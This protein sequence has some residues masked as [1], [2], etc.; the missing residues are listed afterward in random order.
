MNI[1]ELKSKVE[2]LKLPASIAYATRFELIKSIV[3]N[4]VQLAKID[5][6]ICIDIQDNITNNYGSFDINNYI[7]DYD[8][9]TLCMS[10]QVSN[11]QK[12]VELDFNI[13]IQPIKNDSHDVYIN[14][15]DSS[16]NM[17]DPIHIAYAKI[18]S[19]IYSKFNTFVKC[20]N[21]KTFTQCTNDIF[22]L[23]DANKAYELAKH[24]Y[25]Q[26]KIKVGTK[27]KY[28]T[29]YGDSIF[30]IQHV[31]EKRVWHNMVNMKSYPF[32]GKTMT[33]NELVN[34]INDGDCE[35]ISNE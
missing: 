6:D 2:S 30:E 26:S 19:T 28:I 14:T 20:A 9:P 8:I 7:Y 25:I 22:A 33:K 23:I 34:L 13:E 4:C 11:Q 16:L 32:N 29:P 12:N 15:S 5:N 3:L 10:I 18:L 17:K 1:E 21:S 27:L 35:I 31:S 24:E